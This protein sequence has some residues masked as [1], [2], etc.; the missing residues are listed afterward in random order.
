MM[1]VGFRILLTVVSDLLVALVGLDNL[2]AEDAED[3]EKSGSP[4]FVDGPDKG[5][6]SGVLRSD[7]TRFHSAPRHS[8]R[9]VSATSLIEATT[10]NPFASLASFLERRVLPSVRLPLTGQSPQ[11]LASSASSADKFRK[12]ILAPS[13]DWPEFIGH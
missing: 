7:S 11:F 13:A 6:E 2:S 4:L 12:S 3:A 8:K 5:G 1:V 10:S 9:N